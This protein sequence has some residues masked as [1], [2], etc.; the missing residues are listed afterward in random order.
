MTQFSR[1]LNQLRVGAA[2][3]ALAAC[4]EEGAPPVEFPASLEPIGEGVPFEGADCRQLQIN[5]AIERWQ[6]EAAILIG[7][8]DEE[9]ANMIAGSV[10]GIVDGFFIIAARE[11]EGS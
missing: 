6:E 8:P 11:D 9:S 4:A 5:Q 1:V 10:V 2:L 7:C 3:I